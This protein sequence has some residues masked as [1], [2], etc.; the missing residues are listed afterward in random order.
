MPQTVT[1][2]SGEIL[3]LPEAKEYLQL[4]PENNADD[5]EIQSLLRAAR[6]EAEAISRRTL[7]E[8]VTRRQELRH[9]PAERCWKFQFPPLHHTPTVTVEYY[10]SSDNLQTV[11]S[12]DYDIEPTLSSGQIHAGM[13]MLIFKP[14]YAL[15]QLTSDR[16]GTR[17]IITYITGWGDWDAVS[18]ELQ[19]MVESARTAIKILLWDGYHK[20]NDENNRKRAK[21][22]LGSI[23]FGWYR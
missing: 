20:E 4:D 10:D 6:H 8:S 13:S 7:R 11:A 23:A 2:S 3:T 18:E 1:A 12:S 17:I 5:Q 9:W 21:Q 19:G 14:N 22:I 16:D 15:P